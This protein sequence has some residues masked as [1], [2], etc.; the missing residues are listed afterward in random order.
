M[1]QNANC[2]KGIM[3]IQTVTLIRNQGKSSK[4]PWDNMPAEQKFL[5]ELYTAFI[6]SKG[7]NMIVLIVHCIKN[8]SHYCKEE[9]EQK[10]Y[11]IHELLLF[12]FQ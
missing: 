11:L 2:D 10:D 1:Q 7:V 12:Y 8:R 5:L 3:Q 9:S 4:S 6:V